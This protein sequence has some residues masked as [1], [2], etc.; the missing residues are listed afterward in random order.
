[1][2]TY[3]DENV[4][5]NISPDYDG[6]GNRGSKPKAA[7]MTMKINVAE[8][9]YN[10]RT[11]AEAIKQL[12]PE[13]KNYGEDF[14][15]TGSIVKNILRFFMNKCYIHLSTDPKHIDGP[16]NDRLRQKIDAIT[17]IIGNY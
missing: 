3:R 14:A 10:F 4:T 6:Y 13:F 2:T 5:I 7:Y 8:T 12:I 11:G 17:G 1:M 15:F 9:T 16:M